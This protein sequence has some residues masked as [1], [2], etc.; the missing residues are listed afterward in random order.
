MESPKPSF[1]T[2]AEIKNALS[3]DD[4]LLGEVFRLK[5]SGISSALELAKKSGAS[6]RGVIYHNLHILNCLFN[7]ELPTGAAVSRFAVQ[8]IDRLSKNSNFSQESLQYLSILKNLLR[9]NAEKISALKADQ[10]ELEER[11]DVLAKRAENFSHA[12][13]VYSYPT[14]IHFGTVGDPSLMWLKIG[15]T[16]SNVWKRILEQS[17]QTAMPEDPKLLRIYHAPNMNVF[18]IEKKFHETLDS[19]GHSR[20]S[21][22]QPRAG[23][24]WFATSLAAVDQ[25]A[26]ILNLDIESEVEFFEVD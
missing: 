24:E 9:E 20:S 1:E 25:L 19:F 17:R 13:Y 2:I 7:G 22:S 10:Q 11:S 6:G 18:E 23:K 3:R 12:V 26:K 15:S 5:E 4:K 14:Y 21:T 16:T 8:A